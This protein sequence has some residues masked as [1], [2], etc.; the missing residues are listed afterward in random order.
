MSFTMPSQ[1]ANTSPLPIGREIVDTREKRIATVAWRWSRPYSYAAEYRARGFSDDEIR[2]GDALGQAMEDEYSKNRRCYGDPAYGSWPARAQQPVK[3]KVRAM[4][5][6]ENE[7]SAVPVMIAA[8]AVVVTTLAYELIARAAKAR[9]MARFLHQGGLPSSD[10]ERMT[11]GMWKQFH[12]GL[13]QHRILG[14]HSTESSC[15]TV[16]RAIA[17]LRKLEQIIPVCGAARIRRLP[18]AA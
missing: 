2:E 9:T 5:R 13:K 11:P 6:G 1:Q 3:D 15:E 8:P 10:A 4:L 7:P 12:A 14:A 17:E 18:E 16:A